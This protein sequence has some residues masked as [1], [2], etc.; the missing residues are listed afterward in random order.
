MKKLLIICIAL[1]VSTNSLYAQNK[2]IKGRVIDDFLETT[3]GVLIM[4]NDTV[5][6]GKT[7]LNGFFQIEIPV[8]VKKILFNTV[9]IELASIELVDECDEVEVVMM[10]RD[11]Y[12]F[13][14]LKK[15]DRLRMKR[16]KQL[17]ELHKEAFEKGIFKTDK[18]CYT[19]EF[20]PYYKK[21]Q[22]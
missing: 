4:I 19:Q 12:D 14:K 3:P 6:V 10:L 17:P 9:G 11:S 18:A 20:I 21:K 22:K 7:D 5:E 8:S 1:G 15:I 13:I 2:T 16:F